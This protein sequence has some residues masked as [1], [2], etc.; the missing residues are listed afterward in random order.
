[1]AAQNALRLQQGREPV[2]VPGS[3][4]LSI[5]GQ[6]FSR[7]NLAAPAINYLRE[8]GITNYTALIARGSNGDNV[9]QELA[10]GLGY[11]KADGSPDLDRLHALK[12]NA[13]ADLELLRK[14]QE[15]E[16]SVPEARRRQLRQPA[17]QHQQRRRCRHLHPDDP[18]RC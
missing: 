10:R 17:G 11:V 18:S 6:D 14:R 2:A 3:T 13:A 1:M 16:S 9:E 5:A 8:Q 15:E 4:W 7:L 12:T